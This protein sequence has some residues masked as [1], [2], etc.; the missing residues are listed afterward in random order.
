MERVVLHLA[1]FGSSDFKKLL[2]ASYNAPVS[3]CLVQEFR[4]YLYCNIK[5]KFSED[6][7]NPHQ[8]VRNQAKIFLKTQIKNDQ[9]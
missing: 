8:W 9:N 2:T 1:K 5:N 6:F 3:D 7:R 4:N